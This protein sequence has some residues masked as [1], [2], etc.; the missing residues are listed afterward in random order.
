MAVAGG[1]ETTPQRMLRM[2]DIINEPLEFLA[3]ISG[4]A[5]MPLVSLEQALEPLVSILPEVQ[6]HVYVAKQRC[7][8]PADNLT[9]DESASIMLY[10]MSWE[11][12]EECL[13][14]VLNQTLRSANRQQ[15]LKPWYSY[16]RLFLNA[17]LRLPPLNETIYRGVKLNM[18]DRYIKGETVVWWG[19]SSSTS[20][21]EVLQSDLFL[22]K[23]GARTIFTIKCESARDIRKHS[24]FPEES[25]VLVLAATQFEVM[26]CLDQG[27]LRII[28]L[29]ETRPPHALMQL[30]PVVGSLLQSSPSAVPKENASSTANKTTAPPTAESCHKLVSKPV[31]RNAHLEQQIANQKGKTKLDLRG[32]SLTN[33]DMEIV[34]YYA[35]QEN[36]TLTTLNLSWNKIGDAGAQYVSDALRHN[37]TLTVLDLYDNEIGDAGAQYVSDALRHNT[38]LTTLH[39]SRNQIGEKG[40]QYVSDALRHNTTLTTLYLSRNQ[41]GD[42]GA[43]YVSDALRHN[44]TLTILNLSWNEIGDAGAQYVSDALRHNTTLTALDLSRNKIGDAGAQYVSDALRHNT[45]LT[46]LYLSFNQIGDAGAQYV[47]D[48]LRH[49]TTLT[50]LVLGSNKIGEKGAQDLRSASERNGNLEL[51]F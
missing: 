29:K 10:T 3:P 16:L 38:T 35:I 32:N 47:S 13:Y 12:L 40:A 15:K 20:H 6:S 49:N 48:A 33:K 34:A 45:T 26:S 19:F 1:N 14:N 43:Q 11:P 23:T 46:A 4:Y 44:T 17:L 36:N 42:A 30:P 8:K 22:G 21:V 31:Y 50:T 51:F 18:S 37:T 7:K 27:D 9:Q 39:L 5:E 41:I 25:E 2:T 24:Y 28:Q